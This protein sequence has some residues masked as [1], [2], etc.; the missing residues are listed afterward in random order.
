M[1]ISV[2]LKRKGEKDSTLIRK[3]DPIL[4]P[5]T[6]RKRKTI[7]PL[8]V[9]NNDYH[10]HFNRKI[11]PKLF[12]SNNILISTF[13]KLELEGYL[14]IQTR[15]FM[16]GIQFISYWFDIFIVLMILLFV[17]III[18]GYFYKWIQKSGIRNLFL[19]KG[20]IYLL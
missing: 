8:V 2:E 10:F 1:K 16:L 7:L 17:Y 5:L 12:I 14:R 9:L 6:M 20:N 3:K 15:R 13:L 19:T 4:S 18:L 11:F